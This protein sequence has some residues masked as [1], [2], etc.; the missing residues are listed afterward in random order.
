MEA[1][2]RITDFAFT[3]VTILSFKLLTITTPASPVA[4]LKDLVINSEA[5]PFLR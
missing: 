4:V 2:C 5:I 3:A 1:S